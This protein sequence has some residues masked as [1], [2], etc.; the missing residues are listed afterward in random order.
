MLRALLRLL[1]MVTL[2]IA[3]VMAVLDATRSIAAEA[4]VLTPLGDS[5]RAVAPTLL[6]MIEDSITAGL[7][8]FVWNPVMT[9]LLAIPGFAVLAALALL[10]AIAGRRARHPAGRLAF[11]R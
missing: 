9:G 10:L 6:R 7:P 5:W 2:A 11:G 8:G 1:S 4:V 3:V